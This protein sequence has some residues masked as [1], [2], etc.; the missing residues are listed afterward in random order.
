MCILVHE[1]KLQIC[2]FLSVIF[3]TFYKKHCDDDDDD[4]DD[5]NE[6]FLWYG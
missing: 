5:D 2:A 6:L 4:D 1:D 3:H